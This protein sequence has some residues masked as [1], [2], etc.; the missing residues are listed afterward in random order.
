MIAIYIQNG[1]VVRVEYQNETEAEVYPRGEGYVE[2]P[3]VE[4]L[5]KEIDYY[6]VDLDEGEKEAL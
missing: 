3:L 5:Q 2:P 6:V 4:L 1:K